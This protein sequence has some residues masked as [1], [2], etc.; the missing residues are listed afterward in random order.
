MRGV[1][2]RCYRC[3]ENA[4]G[5]RRTGGG[6]EFPR[7]RFGAGSAATANGDRLRNNGYRLLARYG[8]PTRARTRRRT[9]VRAANGDRTPPSR[10]AVD[11]R[12]SVAVAYSLTSRTR[13]ARAVSDESPA[14]RPSSGDRF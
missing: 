1:S 11:V 4:R 8:F 13:H 12:A 3:C 10:H 2:E 6:K 7:S 9:L 14:M 5:R